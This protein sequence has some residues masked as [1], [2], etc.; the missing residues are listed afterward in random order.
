[1]DPIVPPTKNSLLYRV[2]NMPLLSISLLFTEATKTHPS[3]SQEGI[4]LCL[5]GSLNKP[6]QCHL[7]TLP[8]SY[9]NRSGSDGRTMSDCNVM[10]DVQFKYCQP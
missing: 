4:V 9:S 2:A 5:T 3:K 10:D 8:D 6:S 7:P 1:M